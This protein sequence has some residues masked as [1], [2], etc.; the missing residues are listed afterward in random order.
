[1]NERY[2][3]YIDEF[4]ERYTKSGRKAVYG[5]VSLMCTCNV[6]PRDWMNELEKVGLQLL[7]EYKPSTRLKYMRIIRMF[8]QYVVHREQDVHGCKNVRKSCTI[9]DSKKL[10]KM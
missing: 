4:T 1:M 5:F 10:Y 6:P 2:L 3:E 7:R 8:I 9:V